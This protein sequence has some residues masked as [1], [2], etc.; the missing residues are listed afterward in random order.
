MYCTLHRVGNTT[1]TCAA[2]PDTIYYR[3]T[4]H[5]YCAHTVQCKRPLT[6]TWKFPPNCNACTVLSPYILQ[7]YLKQVLYSCKMKTSQARPYCTVHSKHVSELSKPY[8][9]QFMRQHNKE[10]Y[11]LIKVGRDLP[12]CR[13]QQGTQAVCT[14]QQGSEQQVLLIQQ[15]YSMRDIHCTI[16]SLKMPGAHKALSCVV[17]YRTAFCFPRLCFAHFPFF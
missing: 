16:I 4:V 15:M 3:H 7:A 9:F 1:Q 11:Y 6:A 8:L 17:L 5:H 14:V 2:P 12:Y 13:V 10:L